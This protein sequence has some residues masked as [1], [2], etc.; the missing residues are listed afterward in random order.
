MARIR[1]LHPSIFTDEAYM[2]LSFAARELIKGLWC[3]A[4]DHGVFEWKPLTLKARLMPADN[5]DMVALMAELTAGRFVLLAEHEG[6][7][8]GAVRNFGRFQRPKKPKYVHPMSDEFRTWTA[9]SADSSPPDPVE[10]APVPK[11]GEQPPQRKEGGGNGSSEPN[12]SGAEGA[13]FDPE[14]V[15]FDHGRRYLEN[16]G[17]TEKQARALLGK[18]RKALGD[19]P[20]IDALGDAKRDN[21]QEPVAWMEGVV[22]QRAKKPG[23]SIGYVPMGVGG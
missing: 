22:K 18:W 6:R 1:S 17:V 8:L 3:E 9:S 21:V 16:H 11:K 4:D 2:A 13:E 20:L 15:I 14:R 10:D 5:V 7:Q 12:G 19:G 23:K